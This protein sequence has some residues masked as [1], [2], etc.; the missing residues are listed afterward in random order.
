M[1]LFNL[2]AFISQS[3]DTYQWNG[4]KTQTVLVAAEYI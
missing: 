4:N 1:C 2:V 3:V